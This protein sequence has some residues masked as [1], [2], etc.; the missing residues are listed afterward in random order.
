MF[1]NSDNAYSLSI[2]VYNMPINAMDLIF[3]LSVDCAQFSV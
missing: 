1:F 3:G 2:E